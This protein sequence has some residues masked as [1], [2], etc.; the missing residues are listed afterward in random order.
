MIRRHAITA[1]RRALHYSPSSRSAA[2]ENH[3]RFGLVTNSQVSTRT[4][5]GSSAGSSCCCPGDSSC[6][7]VSLRV[8]ADLVQNR[9]L[10]HAVDG[11]QRGATLHRVVFA[12]QVRGR[13][14]LQRNPRVAAL[15]RA[16]VHQ[17]VF[18][19]IQK[20][21]PRVAFPVVRNPAHQVFLEAVVAEEGEH[22]LA[23]VVDLIENPPFVL[24]Q[25]PQLSAS[26]RAPRPS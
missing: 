18:A 13:I 4:E 1:R 5:A 17:S 7:M 6:T 21:A 12:L 16:P 3:P 24:A 25:R 11:A 14:F 10:M 9:R 2:L 22:R 26:R 20:P 23:Q 8:F 15:L 19:D